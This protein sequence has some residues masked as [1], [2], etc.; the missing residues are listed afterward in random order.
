MGECRCTIEPSVVFR[1]PVETRVF[2]TVRCVLF[3]SWLRGGMA[4]PPAAAAVPTAPLLP[5]APA[6]VDGLL[7]VSARVFF[8]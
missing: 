4:A 7:L 3:S 2:D 8:T 6:N 5:L 1:E